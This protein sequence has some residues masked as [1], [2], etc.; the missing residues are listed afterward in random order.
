MNDYNGQHGNGYQPHASSKKD[1]D[2]AWPRSQREE[3]I[4]KQGNNP[5]KFNWHCAII[6]FSVSSLF[7][8]AIMVLAR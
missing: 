5:D 1:D 7:W 6:G 3:D 8:A 4:F 2:L